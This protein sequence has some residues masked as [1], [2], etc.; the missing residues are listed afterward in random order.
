MF[1]TI[2]QDA[3]ATTDLS[4]SISSTIL[5][6]IAALVLGFVISCAYFII[7]PK[8]SRSASFSM[9]LIV[10]PAIVAIIILL[11]G[12][13][14]ARAFSLA[15]IFTLVR[16]RSI[17]G[18]SKDISFI[19]LTM[20][21]GLSVGLGY[22]TLGAAITVILGV[23]IVVINQLGFGASKQKEKRLKITIPEDMNYQDVF[24]DLFDQY[25]SFY[26]MNKV[27][28]TNMGTLFELNYD[29]V[30]KESASEKE[31]IDAIR[32]RNGNLNIQLGIKENNSQQL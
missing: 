31:F 25:T 15:G 9:S 23:V 3:A 26:E 18:D 30:M 29:I 4:I 32:C 16:F 14:V 19:F 6:L 1:E 11:V 21:V 17:P 10:L 27:K 8:R 5:S 28:T 12:E 13:N 22:L 20:A 7:T 2:F 24:N